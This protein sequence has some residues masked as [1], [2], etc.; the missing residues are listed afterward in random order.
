[1]PN[2]EQRGR[3]HCKTS[4]A[5]YS[6]SPVS[7]SYLQYR[8]CAAFKHSSIAIRFRQSISFG[9]AGFKPQQFICNRNGPIVWLSFHLIFYFISLSYLI[10]I[11]LHPI[12]LIFLLSSTIDLQPVCSRPPSSK[13]N[14]VSRADLSLSVFP[15][16][17]REGGS[18]TLDWYLDWFL[19]R[20]GQTGDLFFASALVEVDNGGDR[21]AF[22]LWGMYPVLRSARWGRILTRYLLLLSEWDCFAPLVL[23]SRGVR[24]KGLTRQQVLSWRCTT[25]DCFLR[26]HYFVPFF[27]SL[28][29]PIFRSRYR[30]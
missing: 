30:V 6:E 11:F 10:F 13:G 9:S 23:Y 29:L 2:E 15:A 28:S 7:C 27:L 1:M 14:T 19:P 17:I 22:L 18:R 24:V 3:S 16:V 5:K 21:V 25:F 20:T 4:S 12:S 26:I 8:L